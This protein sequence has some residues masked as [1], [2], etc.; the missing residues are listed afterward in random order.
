MKCPKCNE[1]VDH[2]IPRQ[3]SALSETHGQTLRCAAYC[4]PLCDAVLGVESD[5]VMR[6]AAAAKLQQ[7]LEALAKLVHEQ[8]VKAAGR[9]LGK[10]G[11]TPLV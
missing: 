6:S 9:G 2:V 8:S 4:C 5:P 10:G 7:D 1:M 11:H 3:I